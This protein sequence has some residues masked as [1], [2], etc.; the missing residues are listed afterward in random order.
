[1]KSIYIE[2]VC[3]ILNAEMS[4]VF[5]LVQSGELPGAKIGRS[6]VF[7]ESVVYD[8]LHQQIVSQTA[9]RKAAKAS[10]V[11]LREMLE[12]G[13]LPPDPILMNIQPN[14]TKRG[15]KR[16]EIPALPELACQVTAAI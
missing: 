3:E 8:Y 5:E 6:W 1:M 2:Q 15:R 4:R 14:D 7:I 10:K 9:R 16:R 13:M 11:E 12:A